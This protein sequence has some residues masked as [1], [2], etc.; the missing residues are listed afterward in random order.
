MIFKILDCHRNHK[1]YDRYTNVNSNNTDITV[2]L[3]DKENNVIEGSVNEKGIF[4][5]ENV[6][7]GDITK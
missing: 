1:A 7:F 6:V 4:R 2:S 3:I 5:F